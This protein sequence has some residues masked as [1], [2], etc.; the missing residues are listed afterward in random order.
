[1]SLASTAVYRAVAVEVSK[2]VEML[3]LRLGEIIRNHSFGSCA[4]KKTPAPESK[5]S[6]IHPSEPLEPDLR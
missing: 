6:K 2:C 5:L 1:V 4:E 3:A